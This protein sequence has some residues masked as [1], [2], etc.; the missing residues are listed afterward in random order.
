MPPYLQ[1]DWTHHA[2]A[3]FAVVHAQAIA[4]V[5]LPYFMQL[6]DAVMETLGDLPQALNVGRELYP[7]THPGATVRRWTHGLLSV[8]YAVYSNEL[9][10]F[11]TSYTADPNGW[12]P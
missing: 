7:L 6:H 5:Q 11:V 10:C 12:P 3:G 9:L 4:L 2:A 1:L 8:I